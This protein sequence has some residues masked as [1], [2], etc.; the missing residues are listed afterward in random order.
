MVGPF[1]HVGVDMLQLP[2]TKRG[3]KYVVVF[4]DYMMKWP[5]AYA[6]PD[7]IA[8]PIAKL[9]VGELKQ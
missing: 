8:P 6:V 5:E 9:F 3:N 2:R 7:Q 4:M 1:D